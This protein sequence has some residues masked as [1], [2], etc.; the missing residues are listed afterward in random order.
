MIPNEL[1]P[2]IEK[3][4][5]AVGLGKCEVCNRRMSSFEDQFGTR[6]CR[7]CAEADRCWACGGF[8]PAG[9]PPRC[10]RCIKSSVETAHDT[11]W[12]V[13]PVRQFVHS[14]G[15]TMTNHCRVL[16][17][18][19]QG[20]W[21][22]DP[23]RL[24]HTLLVGA[25]AL[26]VVEIRI[27]AGLPYT[28]FGR[29]LAHEMAHGWLARFGSDREPAEE[30]GI[31]ELVGSWWLEDRGGPFA[32]SL[33]QMMDDNPDPL[34]GGGFRRCAQIA[35]GLSRRD[36]VKVIQSRGRLTDPKR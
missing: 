2:W 22:L 23:S 30:E 17:G 36:V 16:L 1:T 31:C 20:A 3:V 24:G 4:V 34:Y 18:T 33:R 25:S 28:L 21:S 19:G 6:A 9:R 8:A 13:P 26:Q 11:E 35:S 29:V 12:A 15:I 7:T 27:A 10:T 14:L 32:E 5:A